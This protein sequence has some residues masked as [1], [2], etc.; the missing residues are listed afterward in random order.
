MTRSE[1]RDR[2]LASLPG[3]GIPTAELILVALGAGAATSVAVSIVEQIARIVLQQRPGPIAGDATAVAVGVLVVCLVRGLDRAAL[4]VP[5][6]HA[7]HLAATF[8]IALLVYVYLGRR[9]VGDPLAQLGPTFTAVLIAA[10]AGAAIGTIARTAIPRGEAEHAPLLLRAIGVA[11]V[12]GTIVH[13]FWPSSFFIAVAGSGRPDDVR[14][15]ALSLP[16]LFAGAIAGGIY[17]ARRGAG[18]VGLLVLGAFLAIPSLIAQAALMPSQVARDPTLRGSF[19]VLFLLLALRI[20]AWPLA[21]AFTHGFLTPARS[22][23]DQ[24][25]AGGHPL[26]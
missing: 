1:L 22:T 12:V 18:Y 23:D 13:V 8:F 19:A 11:V 17:A 6:V 2:A 3:P 7:V 4:W 10:A 5:L 26:I 14:S 21:A 9:A 25:L 16:D 20:A 24:Q 15:V